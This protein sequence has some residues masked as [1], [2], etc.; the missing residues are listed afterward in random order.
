MVPLRRGR[1]AAVVLLVIATLALPLVAQGVTITTT[2]GVI[3]L[4]VP[5]LPILEG[6]VLERLLAGRSVDLEY[7][8]AISE[9]RAGSAIARTRQTFKV[10][11]DL[12]EE[13]F[14]VTRV[15]TP[16]R[17]VSHLLA[18]EAELWCVDALAI[19]RTSVQLHGG[20]SSRVWIRLEYRAL[21]EATNT[22]THDEGPLTLRT[23]I[24]ALSRKKGAAGR[25]RVLEGGPFGLSD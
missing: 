2:G 8:L 12:W 14:A 23:L 21:A 7:D 18:R 25:T 15:G 16:P 19:P 9:S 4:K 11:Y 24:D 17:S 6:E 20:S 13:R 3:R 5:R 1:S 10:S 22:P